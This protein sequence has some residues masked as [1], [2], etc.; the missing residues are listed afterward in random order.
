[1]KGKLRF[2]HSNA[3]EKDMVLATTSVGGS[4]I[5]QL[6]HTMNSILFNFME[7]CINL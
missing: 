6:S 2:T 1:M 5:N 3:N 7:Y 4:D